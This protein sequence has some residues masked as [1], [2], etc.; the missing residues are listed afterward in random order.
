MGV[1][2]DCELRT[3]EGGILSRVCS[4]DEWC[5]AQERMVNE[6]DGA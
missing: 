6:G 4:F 2:E 5:N 3:A 1:A